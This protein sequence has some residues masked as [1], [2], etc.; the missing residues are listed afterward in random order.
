MSEHGEHCVMPLRG[1]CLDFTTDGTRAGALIA[2][3]M[4]TDSEDEIVSM[5]RPASH[6]TGMDEEQADWEAGQ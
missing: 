5:G 3:T 1:E 6:L 2:H 4:G